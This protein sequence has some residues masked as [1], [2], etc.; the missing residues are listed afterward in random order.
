MPKIVVKVW[1]LITEGKMEEAMNLQQ[2]V[3]GGD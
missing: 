1:N 2:V 3:S